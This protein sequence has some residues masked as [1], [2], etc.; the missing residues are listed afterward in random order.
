MLLEQQA[1]ELTLELEREIAQRKQAE[2][3]LL[4]SETR[5]RLLAEATFEAIAITE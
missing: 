2:Q 3:A 4:E 1:A 5:F